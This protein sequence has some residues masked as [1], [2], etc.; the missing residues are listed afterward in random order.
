MNLCPTCNKWEV[1]EG[2]RY[3]LSCRNRKSNL[4]V[5][6]GEVVAELVVIVVAILL[7]KRKEK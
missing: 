4:I 2:E 1:E 6:A 3:C 5:K 7:G